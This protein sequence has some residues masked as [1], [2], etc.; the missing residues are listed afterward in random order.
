MAFEYD[1]GRPLFVAD[2]ANRYTLEDC[3]SAFEEVFAKDRPVLVYIHGRA[4][5]VGEPKKGI[6]TK[7]Y[8]ALSDYGLAVFGFTW[9]AS[10]GGYDPTRPAAFADDFDHVLGHLAHFL[11]TRPTLRRPSLLAHSIGNVILAELAKEDRLTSERGR[12][13]RNIVLNAA[14]VRAR[15]HHLWMRK[16]GCTDRRY[17]VVNP[18]DLPLRFAGA[19]FRP[20][21]LGCELESP[22]CS[23]ENSIYVDLGLLDVNHRYFVPAGQN[24]Q[25]RLKAFFQGVLSGEAVDL[26]ALASRMEVEGKTVYRIR[27]EKSGAAAV[28]APGEH[29]DPDDD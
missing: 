26:S 16:L 7:V 20:D 23:S 3:P 15:R 5:G 13:F 28:G 4:K 14:A 12:L 9:D 10:A 27:K 25:I 8:R 19:L 21:M 17:V 2:T 29:E 22:D 1:G 6:D 11:S 24:G 18:T